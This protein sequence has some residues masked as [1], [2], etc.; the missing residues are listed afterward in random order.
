MTLQ[1]KNVF[2]ELLFCPELQMQH[3]YGKQFNFR[4]PVLR[5]SLNRSTPA[6]NKTHSFSFHRARKLSQRYISPL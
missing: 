4:I 2:Y 6:K 5:K 1:L 3:R